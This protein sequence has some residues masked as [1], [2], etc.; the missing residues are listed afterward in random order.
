MKC[1]PVPCWPGHK[2]FFA[3]F[4]A[5]LCISSCSPV[6]APS[7]AAT[8]RPAVLPTATALVTATGTPAAIPTIPGGAW[9]VQ[10]TGEIDINVDVN[11]FNLDLFDTPP[12]LIRELRRRGVFVICYF[13]A[14]SYE[15]WRPDASQF[16][17]QALGKD[18]KGWPGEKWLDIRRL[19]LLASIMEA[20]LELAAAKG[21]DGV[22]PDNVNG[23][24]NDTGFPLTAQDQLVYN[25]FLAAAAHRRG[26]A[27]GLKNDLDQLAE[28]VP[29]FDWV[30]SEGC[31]RYRECHLLQPFLEAGKPVFVIEYELSPEEICPQANQMG[32]YALIKHWE[33]D[34]YRV[35]CRRFSSGP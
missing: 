14:G 2:V 27:V 6:V 34:A 30:T 21:C 19:D 28:L 26:L 18:M 33:L 5:F 25:R 29:Y 16:P 10:Y 9:Q 11:V 31:F 1:Y 24:E 12:E 35:D 15:D 32:F 7:P 22:E 13:S 3:Y 23:Y 17:L 4:L 8:L 20:R